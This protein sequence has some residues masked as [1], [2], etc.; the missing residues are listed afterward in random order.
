[1]AIDLL[2]KLQVPGPCVDI[3]LFRGAPDIIVNCTKLTDTAAASDVDEISDEENV[4]IE[5]SH[6]RPPLKSRTFFNVPE[7]LGEVFAGLRL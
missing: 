7:K 1:M 4:L 5:N 2:G 3:F 6:Q